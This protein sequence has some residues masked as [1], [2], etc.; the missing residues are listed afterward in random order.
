MAIEFAPSIPCNGDERRYEY[1]LEG[2]DADWASGALR[3]VNYASLAPGTYTFNARIVGID[4]PQGAH[5]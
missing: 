3:T 2:Y 4:G 5:G 1:Q